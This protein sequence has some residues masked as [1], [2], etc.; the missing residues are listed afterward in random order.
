MP[1]PVA[2]SAATSAATKGAGAASAASAI[3]EAGATVI[4]AI[5]Q[6]ND[7]NKRRK[8]EQNFSQ[9]TLEQQKGLEIKLIEAKN[10]SQKLA[11]LSEY[12]T[13]L[14]TQR[15]ANLANFYSDKE[16]SKRTMLLVLAG[17]IAVLAIVTLIVIK[18]K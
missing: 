18:K 17:G 13:Q 16:K 7:A 3:G 15:I 11:V 4:S 12:L 9:L 6:I 5:S 8:F 2:T 1:A 10:Q 14:N